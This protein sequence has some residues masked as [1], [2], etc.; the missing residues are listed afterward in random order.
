MP[1]K[2]PSVLKR[3]RTIRSLSPKKTKEEVEESK[4]QGTEQPSINRRAALTRSVSRS[5]SSSSKSCSGWDC[6]SGVKRQWTSSRRHLIIQDDDQQQDHD[7]DHRRQHLQ[8]IESLR[9]LEAIEESAKSKRFERSLQRTVSG[10][11][12]LSMLTSVYD[13]CMDP[14]SGSDEKSGNHRR[15]VRIASD[16][17]TDEASVTSVPSLS[18]QSA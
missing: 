2:A 3:L 18:S 16:N 6:N 17:S 9:K 5:F 10:K 15:A 8:A 1:S 11:S 4:F 7:D 13:S 14:N 12:L